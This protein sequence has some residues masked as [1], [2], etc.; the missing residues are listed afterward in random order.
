M[1]IFNILVVFVSWNT[2]KH[3]FI[4]S[5]KICINSVCEVFHTTPQQRIINTTNILS[6]SLQVLYKLFEGFKNFQKCHNNNWFIF[7]HHNYDLEH[8]FSY[9]TQ[10]YHNSWIK[11][12]NFDS[13]HC[14]GFIRNSKRAWGTKRSLLLHKPLFL[15]I[16]FYLNRTATCVPLFYISCH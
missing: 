6:H 15:K 3:T 10:A 9:F 5:P 13:I 1:F 4:Y 2:H 12:D 11:Y 16:S 14:C 7:L 8:C